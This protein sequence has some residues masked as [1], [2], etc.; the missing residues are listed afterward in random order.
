MLDWNWRVLKAATLFS[1]LLAALCWMAWE[2]ATVPHAIGGGLVALLLEA[3]LY[4]FGTS[5]QVRQTFDLTRPLHQLVRWDNTWFRTLKAVVEMSGLALMAW[6]AFKFLVQVEIVSFLFAGILM[7][8]VPAPLLAWAY[9]RKVLRPARA[10]MQAPRHPQVLPPAPAVQR[11]G[12]PSMAPRLPNTST[13]VPP[14]TPVDDDDS[15][16]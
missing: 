14:A 13:R 1:L 11:L 6:F 2:T 15:V 4:A 3:A 16:F 10:A 12:G 5:R 7:T 9:Y 8:S